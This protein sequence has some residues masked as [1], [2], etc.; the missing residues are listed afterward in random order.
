[1]LPLLPALI[2]LIL[3]GPTNVERMAMD[4]RLPA[5]LQAIHHQMESSGEQRAALSKADGVALVS[6]LAMSGDPQFTRALGRLLAISGADAFD[7]LPPARAR[8]EIEG[9]DRG[10][11]PPC[12]RLVG[13]L[14]DG[15]IL[16]QRS[17][18][19]PFLA[20]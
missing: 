18:D 5:A 14:Q 6:L 8:I 20:A 16:S 4:G 13:N 9:A 19:G 17:R 7:E 10:D 11:P 2:L 12:P 3:Q 15:F 1:M